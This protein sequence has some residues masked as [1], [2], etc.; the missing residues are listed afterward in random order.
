MKK[1]LNVLLV[2]AVFSLLFLVPGLAGAG[3]GPGVYDVA[4]VQKITAMTPLGTPPFGITGFGFE[5]DILLGS[6]K[7]GTMTGQMNVVDPP[8]DLTS[9]TMNGF[10]NG[11]VSIPLLGSFQ[12]KGYLVGI[13]DN[14]ILVSWVSA[15]TK[16][17]EILEGFVGLGDGRGIVDWMAGKGEVPFTISLMPLP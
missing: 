3:G 11:V 15:F 8:L 1:K 2:A 12:A 4:L 6:A 10:F 5:A 14:P 13:G 7:V 17:T 16:G 9:P